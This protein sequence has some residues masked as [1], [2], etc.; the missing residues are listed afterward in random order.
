MLSSL[1]VDEAKF[2]ARFMDVY[3]MSLIIAFILT[4]VSFVSAESIINLLFGKQWLESIIIFKC[5]VV[6]GITNTHYSLVKSAI[7]AKSKTSVGYKYDNIKRLVELSSLLGLILGGFDLFLLWLVCTQFIILIIQSIMM[8]KAMGYTNY[9]SLNFLILNLA[10]FSCGSI[11]IDYVISGFGNMIIRDMIKVLLVLGM[12]GLKFLIF[13]S[14]LLKE[15]R[16]TMIQLMRKR[17]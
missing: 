12:I 13:D 8:N 3:Y 16:M 17:H 10:V 7:L 2:K 9:E 1:Q 5:L 14:K 15:V 6:R 4:S 11:Y